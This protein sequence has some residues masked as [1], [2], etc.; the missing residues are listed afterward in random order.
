MMDFVL[1]PELLGGMVTWSARDEER[2]YIITYDNRYPGHGYQ[3]SWKSFD[4]GPKVFIS[5]SDVGFPSFDA[6]K[7][8]LISTRKEMAN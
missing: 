6:A 3:A 8:A 5:D 4:G 2:T 1:L 7:A